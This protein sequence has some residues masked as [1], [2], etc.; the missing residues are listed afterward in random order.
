[1]KRW[2]LICAGL[3][4][5]PLAMAAEPPKPGEE[6]KGRLLR[7]LRLLPLGLAHAD[8]TLLSWVGITKGIKF[9]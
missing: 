6:S 8:I 2:L 1:M 3:G 5:V 7:F 9:F 4:L